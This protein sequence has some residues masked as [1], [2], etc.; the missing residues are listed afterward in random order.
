MT[1]DA[2]TPIDEERKVV[3][4]L[5][6]D[7][8][9]FTE[10]SERHDPEDVRRLLSAYYQA[11]QRHLLRFGGTI[12]KFIG[13]AVFGLFGAPRAHEDDPER[14]VRAALAV[15][16]AIADLRDRHPE[17]G[18]HVRI[19]ITTGEALVHVAPVDGSQ[20]MAWG[21]VVN[22]ASR[23]QTAAPSD[24]ILVDEATY[25]ATSHLIAYEEAEAVRAKGKAQL[26]PAWRPVGPLAF[27]GIDLAAADAERSRLVDRTAEIARLADA[28]TAIERR[29]P[30]LIT[31]VGEPGIGK[32]CLVLE[33][34]RRV[35]G[36]AKLIHWR[37]GRSPPYPERIPFWA[38]GEIVKAQA[39]MLETDDAATAA[40]KLHRAVRDLIRD[41][42]EARAV[43]AELRSLVGLVPTEDAAHRDRSAAFAGWRQFL[44]ALA[45]QRPL[46]LVFE[47]VHWADDGLLDFIEGLVEWGERVPLLIVCTAR[48]ELYARRGTWGRAEA[49][50]ELVLKRLS[51]AETRELIRL[52]AGGIPLHPAATDAI[53]ANAAG[54]PLFS[55]EF[56]RMMAGRGKAEPAAGELPLPDSLRGLVEARLD[57]LPAEEKQLLHAASV[58]GRAVWP[59]ALSRIV[60]RPRRWC[61]EHLD[62]LER[63]EFVTRVRRSSV[64]DEPE[65]RF[66]HVFVREVAYGQ[67][68]RP[69]RGDMHRRAAEWLESLGPD[70]ASDRVQ[71]IAYHYW[72]AHE[73]ARATRGDVAALADR[74]RYALR[75]A[76]DRALALHAFPVAAERFREALELWPAG[77]PERP[78]LLLRLGKSVYYADAG[79]REELTEACAALRDAGAAAGAAEAEAFLASLAHHA[80]RHDQ[81][82]A[83]FDRAVALVADM[84]ATEI[85]ADVLVEY[86]NHA[87]LA[88]ERELAIGPAT[89]ALEIART[90]G[91]REIEARALSIIGMAKAQS[92][93]PGGRALLRRSLEI[94]EDI[95]SHLTADCCGRLADL[96]AQSGDLE[97]CFELHARARRHA[98]RFRHAPFMSWLAGERVGEGYWRGAWDEAMADA[99]RVIAEAEGGARTFM[100]GYCRA[101]R[102]RMRLARGDVSGALDDAARSLRF[103]RAAED[104]QMLDPALAF[105][106][107]AEVAV[108]SREE[109]IDHAAELL[110][111]WLSR[112]DAHP[113]AAWV[114]DLAFAL[115]AVDRAQEL[116]APAA[117]APTKT[118][119]LAAVA[120]F[121]SC[122]FDAAADIFATIGSRPDEAFARL[123]AGAVLRGPEADVRLDAAHAFYARV[124]ATR[125]L[126]EI[127]TLRRAPLVSDP[128]R[129]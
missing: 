119:W 97:A 48:P 128:R 32:S 66:H 65:Y 20:G 93:D 24:G 1:P 27:R 9:D 37:H 59:G 77:D 33:L 18:L 43:E 118:R 89:E 112:P 41:D 26:V 125:H 13:D 86:A 68:L 95:G 107:Y 69:R 19:G 127:A 50:T 80:G 14:A 102:G 4:A 96:E 35:E 81:A 92:G 10:Y 72:C 100:E 34:F 17:P 84:G 85:K 110:G 15:L 121:A 49:A 61:V 73:L 124:G 11:V 55:V 79:G 91:L 90:L 21:D 42:G 83:H 129:S 51:D 12:D 70:R 101:M 113:A 103:A 71:M 106:A 94:S 108:G 104:P 6:C 40:G 74:A 60:G 88:G 47:D 58:V 3:T 126:A 123:R 117:T 52:H 63:K 56:V 64:G 5:F 98:E 54:N 75:D 122:D 82:S 115:H 38:L 22:T 45:R 87:D 76:G 114:V 99:D 25:R 57:A 39:G 109:G 23:L 116:L 53:V 111:N 67:M 36:G 16:E 78:A 31:I 7:I 105:A 29:P 30:H 62:G 44:E 120:A 28:L 8:K 46:V 2:D